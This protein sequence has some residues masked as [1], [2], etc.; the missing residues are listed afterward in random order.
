MVLAGHKER[1]SYALY[2]KLRP[3][4]RN[5]AWPRKRVPHEEEFIVGMLE[6]K[7]VLFNYHSPRASTVVR[8]EDSLQLWELPMI[9]FAAKV[10]LIERDQ[11]PLRIRVS[12]SLPFAVSRVLFLINF[13]ASK[14]LPSQW[15]SPT[16]QG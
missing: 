3:S 14:S 13:K 6:W 1:A 4:G 11:Y 2:L 10:S 16:T 7:S 5:V 8:S 9:E 12:V 15:D